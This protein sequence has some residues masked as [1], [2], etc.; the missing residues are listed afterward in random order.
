MMKK[1][2]YILGTIAPAL[3][4]L[5]AICKL[6]HWPGASVLIT[7]GTVLLAAVYLPVFAMVSIRDTREK[8]KKVNKPLYIAGVVTGFIFLI[9]ILFKIMHWPGA[10]V[11]LL[12]SVFLTVVLFI[13][14]LVK[15]AIRDKEN[16]LQNFSILIFILAMMAVNIMVFALKVSQNVLSSQ[17]VTAM[18][19]MATHDVI[20]GRNALMLGDLQN[21]KATEI[22]DKTDVLDQ[23]LQTI[24][25][26][27]LVASHEDNRAAVASDNTID[28]KKASYF[29]VHK[30]TNG[31]IFGNDFTQGKGEELKTALEEYKDLLLSHAGSGLDD[32]ISSMLYTGPMWEYQTD[33]LDF[34]FYQAPM[35]SAINVLSSLQQKI[36][37]LEGEV[38]RELAIKAEKVIPAEE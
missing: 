22:A 10:N 34:T 31:V 17:V 26:D 19:N 36:R 8:G 28:L 21:G 37:F 2:M 24:M 13:P 33:W 30:S 18:Y 4:I 3:L 29:D 16:Q 5:G 23:Y 9:G 6:Q 38:L 1:F 27:I 20:E 12:F 14:I 15:H 32:A 35:I 25:V 11:S 7:L